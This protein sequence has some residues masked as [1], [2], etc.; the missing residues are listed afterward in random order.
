MSEKGLGSPTAAYLSRKL[1]LS[2]YVAPS[3]ST[4]SMVTPPTTPPGTIRVRSASLPTDAGMS[5]DGPKEEGGRSKVQEG[6]GEEK[7]REGVPRFSE[8]FDLTELHM[9]QTQTQTRARQDRP[10]RSRPP[11]TQCAAVFLLSV[12]P[13]SAR[14]SL[15][16]RTASSSWEQEQVVHPLRSR[17]P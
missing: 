9:V 3:A 13:S 2:N 14:C 15:K 6:E 11:R 4:S 16:T 17:Y 12:L 8:M 7:V 10:T 1:S 5:A